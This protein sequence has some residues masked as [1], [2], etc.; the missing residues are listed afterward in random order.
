M[1]IINLSNNDLS[2]FEFA[3]NMN[4]FLNLNESAGIQTLFLEEAN[5]GEEIKKNRALLD[6]HLALR[7]LGEKRGVQVLKLHRFFQIKDDMN[8]G[9]LWWDFVHLTS[10]GH[11]VAGRWLSPQIYKVLRSRSL[12]MQK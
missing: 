6:N 8:E 2:T 9:R 4:E 5:S 3:D 1:V 11:E 7:S 12:R 10:Y